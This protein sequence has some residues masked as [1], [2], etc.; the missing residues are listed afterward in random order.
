MSSLSLAYQGLYVVFTF[1]SN[2]AIDMHGCKTGVLIGTTLT[3]LGM[4]VKVLINKSF[5][6]CV[7][8]QIIAAAGQPFI[9]NSP[10]KLAAVWFGQNER[11]LA[12][13]ITIVF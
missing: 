7:L 6:I 12:I 11:I 2:Y 1:P 9:L 3:T 8:G 4:V 5:G 10:A 13:T